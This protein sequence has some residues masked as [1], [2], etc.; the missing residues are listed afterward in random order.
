MKSSRDNHLWLQ[1]WHD[2]ITGFHQLAVNPL[3]TRF[4]PKLQLKKGNRIFVPLCGKSLD[5]LWLAQQGYEVIGVELSP[6]AVSNFFSENNL[7]P[8]KQNA[9][10]FTL[11]RHESISIY[12]GD[13]FSLTSIDLGVIDAVYDRAALTALPEDIRQLYVSQLLKIISNRTNVF[14]L[15]IEDSDISV[16]LKQA[17]GIDNE[18]INLYEN[19]FDISLEYVESMLETNTEYPDQPAQRVEY[20]AYKLMALT[21]RD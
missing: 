8:V 15:T 12:C 1:L 20:K 9:G 2:D 21:N 17:Q 14:L 16:P 7:Q 6:L 19:Y 5:M 11:W 4:W 18:I 13:Y 3:L 10:K